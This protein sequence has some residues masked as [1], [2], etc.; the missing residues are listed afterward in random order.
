M[1]DQRIV[2]LYWNRDEDAIL[3][4]QR[5]YGGL[6]QTIANN[7]LGN[8]QD[9][10]ECVNDAYLKVWNSIPPERPESLLSFLSRVV[11][12]ISLDKYR[13]NRAEKRSRGA[14]IMFSE[15]EECLSDESLA[16][17][18]EDEGIVDAINRFLK[19]LDQENR[20]LFVRRY[21]YMDSNEMLAKTFGMN[22]NTIRQRLFRM[23]ENLKK[24]LEKEGI[25]L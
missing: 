13:F 16:A 11:R 3:H 19:T 24:F 15:L 14:D 17:L 25:G 2:D 8:P 5:K 6:C 1:E 23:R 18:N 10:E 4:T 22:D 12:N 21:Y 20:I 7:I 9:A